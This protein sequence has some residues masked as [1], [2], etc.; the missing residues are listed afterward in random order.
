M[1]AARCSKGRPAATNLQQ[2][3]FARPMPP[4]THRP[5]LKYTPPARHLFHRKRRAKLLQIFAVLI[6]GCLPF[7]YCSS[8]LSSAAC[9]PFDLSSLP[10]TAKSTRSRCC[11]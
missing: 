6:G 7:P 11:R 5:V 8:L 1:T 2:R 10:I 4:E 9:L 3:Y